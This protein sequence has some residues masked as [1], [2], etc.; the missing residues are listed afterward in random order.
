MSYEKAMRHWR[1]PRKGRKMFMGFDNGSKPESRGAR[2]ATVTMLNI[3]RWF[4][5]RHEGDYK[6]NCEC[7]KFELQ[8]LRR[9]RG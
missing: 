5:E 9:L 6:Y 4:H 1:N 3:R 2:A 7:I 8:K